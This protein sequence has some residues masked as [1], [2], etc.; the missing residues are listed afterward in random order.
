MEQLKRNKEKNYKGT[1]YKELVLRG[2]KT[3]PQKSG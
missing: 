1:T 2:V 3:K